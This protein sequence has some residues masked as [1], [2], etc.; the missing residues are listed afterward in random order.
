MVRMGGLRQLP[1]PP[2][3]AR[4]GIGAPHISELRDLG[5]MGGP[6]GQTCMRKPNL[7][8]GDQSDLRPGE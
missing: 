1:A 7:T 5:R 6:D 2:E 4:A 3:A 8:L